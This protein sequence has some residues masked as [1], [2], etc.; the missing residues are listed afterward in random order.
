MPIQSTWTQEHLAA[1]ETAIASGTRHVQ[2]GDK[3][4][5]YQTIEQMLRARDVIMSALGGGTPKKLF[6]THSKGL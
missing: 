4:V 6:A 5:T 3:S 2:Y 1:L